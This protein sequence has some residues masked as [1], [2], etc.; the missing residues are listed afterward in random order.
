MGSVEG[1]SSTFES[2]QTVCCFNVFSELER[3]LVKTKKMAYLGDASVNYNF[4]G[5]SR[6]LEFL[7]CLKSPQK[8]QKIKSLKKKFH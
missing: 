7:I 8:H 2:K 5:L 1:S 3:L 4:V 6:H